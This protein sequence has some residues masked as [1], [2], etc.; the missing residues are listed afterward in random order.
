MGSLHRPYR[1]LRTG[2]APPSAVWPSTVWS[3]VCTLS[4]SPAPA[5]SALSLSSSTSS[6]SQGAG[7]TVGRSFRLWVL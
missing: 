3:G 2:L 7:T 5:P 6:L 4:K 1:V